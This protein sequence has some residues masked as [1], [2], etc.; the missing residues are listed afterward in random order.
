MMTKDNYHR[1]PDDE[2]VKG[3]DYKF[4]TDL[5]AGKYEAEI[6]LGLDSVRG[7]DL[8]EGTLIKA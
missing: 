6:N 3:I 5:L 1:F 4:Y 7:K 8:Y 2:K